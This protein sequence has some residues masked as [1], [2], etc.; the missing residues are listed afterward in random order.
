[1][2][3]VKLHSVGK[4]TDDVVNERLVGAVA[5]L[6]CEKE[7]K[8][9]D[10]EAEVVASEETAWFSRKAIGLL[11][12][13]STRGVGRRMDS[14][15]DRRLI[16]RSKN[17]RNFSSPSKI[18][19]NPPLH[20]SLHAVFAITCSSYSKYARRSQSRIY[21]K[22]AN[23]IMENKSFNSLLSNWKD[24]GDAQPGY[25][26]L[27]RSPS[28]RGYRL[29][30]STHARAPASLCGLQTSVP[31]RDFAVKATIA[32]PDHRK[33]HIFI[34]QTYGKT[35]GIEKTLSQLIDDLE[36][37]VVELGQEASAETPENDTDIQAVHEGGKLWFTVAQMMCLF[38]VKRSVVAAPLRELRT[39][40]IISD[41][42]NRKE[43]E[44]EYP[45]H[46]S[47]SR[48]QLLSVPHYDLETVIAVGNRGG[49]SSSPST[50][51]FQTWIWTTLGNR[52]VS[53]LLTDFVLND[54]GSVD[55]TEY[56]SVYIF[57]SMTRSN[58]HKIGVTANVE[59]RLVELRSCNPGLKL[60]LTHATSPTPYFLKVEKAVLEQFNSDGEWVQGDS[61][62][63][64]KSIKKYIRQYSKL[65]NTK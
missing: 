1:M 54:W 44:I 58:C 47:A 10:I 48:V 27:V 13:L 51:K 26:H 5:K 63:I 25:V 45:Y 21:H 42:E 23:I 9:R 61:A 32:T 22:L 7:V 14:I 65:H 24:V 29:V 18:T 33:S 39:Q 36:A 4:V 34:T 40:G 56:K 46:S 2:I 38:G 57:S 60:T 50:D 11:F 64:T 20:Y 8:T 53:E 12:G 35:S 15:V 3:T 43:W 59:R 41:K 55:N 52:V 31:Q 6:C 49:H 30:T 62:E 37:H 19:G 17:T 28:V 16:G